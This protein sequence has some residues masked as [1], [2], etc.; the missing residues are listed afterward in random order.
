MTP[1]TSL[2]AILLAATAVGHNWIDNPSSRSFPGLSKTS[3]CQARQSKLYPHIMVGP[4]QKFA[5]QWSAG[6]GSYTH[7]A[8]LSRE[9]E[10]KLSEL[11]VNVMNEYLREA[12]VGSKST[13]AGGWMSGG[14]NRKVHARFVRQWQDCPQQGDI[15]LTGYKQSV[16]G[17]R[18]AYPYKKRL[19][20]GDPGWLDWPSSWRCVRNPNLQGMNRVRQGGGCKSGAAPMV[21]QISYDERYTRGDI[22]AGYSNAKYPWLVAVYRFK[23][24]KHTPMDSDFGWFEFPPATPAGEYIIQYSWRGYYVSSALL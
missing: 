10:D 13:D 11:N 6:H 1:A 4:G 5:L 12:P 8:F 16:F 15:D 18:N 19:V 2:A 20:T 22:F 17:N 21:C 24:I 23:I 9:N 7:F 14:K 3:P